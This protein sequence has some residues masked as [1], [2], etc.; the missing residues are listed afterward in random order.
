MSFSNQEHSRDIKKI[1]NSSFDVCKIVKKNF[2]R[3]NEYLDF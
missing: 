2:D 1:I 3:N